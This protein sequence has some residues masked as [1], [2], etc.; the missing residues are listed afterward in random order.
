MGKCQISMPEIMHKD[1]KVSAA[2]EDIT[3]KDFILEAIQ[4]KLKRKE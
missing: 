3:I 2:Q 4:D 1:V